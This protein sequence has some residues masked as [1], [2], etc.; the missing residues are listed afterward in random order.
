MILGFPGS[1]RDDAE[2]PRVPTPLVRLRA[3]LLVLDLVG[4]GLADLDPEALTADFLP[5]FGFL[6]TVFLFL[7]LDLVLA[8]PAVYHPCDVIYNKR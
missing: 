7:R 4:L 6:L 8:M 5:V 3:D 1:R 2:L